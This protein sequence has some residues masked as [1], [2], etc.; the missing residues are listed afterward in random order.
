MSVIKSYSVG[1]GDM[2]YIHHNSDNFT[3]IDC[4]LGEGTEDTILAEVARL[5]ASKGITRFISTHPDEDHILGLKTLDDKLGIVNFYVV[6]NSAT[7]TDVTDSFAHYCK[8]RDSERAFKIFKGCARRWMNQESEERKS[9]GMDILW[10]DTENEHFKDALVQAE[11]GDAF[12]NLSPI[13]KYSVT[14][15][16]TVLWMG[17]L[18]TEY[19]ESI[20]DHLKLPHVDILFAPHHG[21]DSGKVP[22]SLLETMT[23]KI[24]VIGEAPCDHLNYYAGYN[25]ITQNTA[26]DIVFDCVEGK[27]HVFTSNEYG[28]DFLVE[29]GQ[30]RR[31]MHY[32][33]TLV[34]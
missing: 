17:D 10:P 2:F 8:L 3:I 15:G 28:A 21:R 29:E 19:M 31:G 11:A 27:C 13:V 9:S 30:L 33:G 22:A 14:S 7:K 20:E 4:C 32:A 6:K 25:T 23:P 26:G 18:E 24:I 12:N 1:N 34:L 16:P 5:S